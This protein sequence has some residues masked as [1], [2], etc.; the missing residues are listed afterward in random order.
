MKKVLQMAFGPVE[1][2][3]SRDDAWL[4]SACSREAEPQNS[5]ILH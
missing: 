3:G 1:I 2:A 5:W 4:I